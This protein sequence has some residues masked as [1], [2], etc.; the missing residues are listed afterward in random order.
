[1]TTNTDLRFLIQ[2]ADQR[3]GQNIYGSGGS[4]QVCQAGTGKKQAIYDKDGNQLNG[5]TAFVALNAGSMKFYMP[6]GSTTVVDI[7]GIAPDGQFFSQ[8]N[9]GASGPNVITVDRN[10]RDQVALIPYAAADSTAAAEKDTGFDFPVG[11][12]I[13]PN[14][15][16]NVL[17]L[18]S[19][20]TVDFGLLSSESGGDAD[21]IMVAMPQTNAGAALAKS[22]STATRGALIGA[23]TLDR[24]AVISTSVSFSYTPSSASAALHG[25]AVIPYTLPAAF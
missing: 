9:I 6:G 14:V 1:M 17:G 5:T 25:L 4:Y 19:G 21:G 12:M 15:G 23:G 16:V 22:A 20:K 11:A 7:Y 2:L 18:E 24:G 8:K 3:D 10:R 13:S